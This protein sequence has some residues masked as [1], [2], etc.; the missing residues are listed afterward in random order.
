MGEWGFSVVVARKLDLN[1]LIADGLEL[2]VALLEQMRDPSRPA[3][4]H[5]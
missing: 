4:T 3:D 5:A 1:R 2:V